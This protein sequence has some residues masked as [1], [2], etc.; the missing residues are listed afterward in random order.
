MK[1]KNKVSLLL[2]VLGIIS[3]SLCLFTTTEFAKQDQINHLTALKADYALL[4]KVSSR[5]TLTAWA[6]HHQ[7]QIVTNSNKP[8]SDLQAYVHK[9]LPQQKMDDNLPTYITYYHQKKYLF[10]LL[11]TTKASPQKVIVKRYRSIWSIANWLI[12]FSIIFGV[13]WACIIYGQRTLFNEENLKRWTLKQKLDQLLSNKNENA[14]QQPSKKQVTIVELQ[15]AV[16]LLANKMD[17]LATDNFLA[18]RQFKSL[19]KHLPVGVMLLDHNG[20][21]ILHNQAMAVILGKNISDEPHYFDQDITTERLQKMIRHTMK[22]NRNH[23]QE[24]QLTNDTNSLVD[25][26]VIRITHTEERVQRQVIVILYD[27][28]EFRQVEQEQIDFVGNVSHE[29]KTPVTSIIGFTDTLLNG[30]MNDHEQSEKFLKIIKQE[31]LRLTNLIKDS[32][33]LT[34]IDQST[35]NK[36]ERIDLRKLVNQ[37]L[38]EYAQASKKAAVTVSYQI[39]G[40]PWISS[41][42]H[43]LTQIIQNLTSNAIKYT[44]PKG[45]IALLL[46]HD[47]IDNYLKLEVSDNGI[48][49]APEDQAHIFERFYRV[50]KSR[51]KKIPGTGL[52]LAIVKQAVQALNGKISVTSKLGVGSCFKILLPL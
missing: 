48:G 16:A 36:L 40:N 43:T 28:T 50:D 5:Q 29:L 23:H 20:N 21:V 31:S 4:D 37:T 11:D 35:Q 7:M 22:Q 46:K 39:Q 10:C 27:L 47:E 32:L 19:M 33:T 24:I 42:K 15:Q 8:R 26:N 14:Y 3:Y 2:L 51:N 52:G 34:K 25:A 41:N 18:K 49:I 13:I 30:A 12:L 1:Q 38:T 9:L 45:K 44:P 6:D 17:K